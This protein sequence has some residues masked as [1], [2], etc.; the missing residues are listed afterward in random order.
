MKDTWLRCNV[1]PGQFSGEYAVSGETHSGEG[2]S[3]FV[4]EDD[5]EC[6]RF[7]VGD[8]RVTGQMRVEILA[9]KGT[10]ALVRLPRQSMENGETITVNR[11]DLQLHRAK[12]EA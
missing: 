8:E 2:F 9:E 4:C 12:Q 3:L 6:R 10:L 11:N 7:P 1:S 5:I